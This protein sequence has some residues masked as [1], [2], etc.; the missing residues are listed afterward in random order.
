[1][2]KE[3]FKKACDKVQMSERQSEGIWERAE[4]KVEGNTRERKLPLRWSYVFSTAAAMI[5][6]CA[7]MVSTMWQSGYSVS[8]ENETEAVSLEEQEE[9]AEAETHEIFLY[10]TTPSLPDELMLM[11]VISIDENNREVTIYPVDLD[12]AIQ[13]PFREDGL[14][15]LYKWM[16]IK[17][18]AKDMTS[19][20]AELFGM[21]ESA[22]YVEMDML[23]LAEIIDACGGLDLEF[24]IDDIREGNVLYYAGR[25]NMPEYTA[26]LWRRVGYI[27]Q[28]DGPIAVGWMIIPKDRGEEELGLLREIE[29]IGQLIEKCQ[30][31]HD[32]ESFTSLLETMN[33]RLNYELS[34]VEL[35]EEVLFGDEQY[36]I[37][38][39]KIAL[40][41]ALH[42]EDLS[43]IDHETIED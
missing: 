10:V 39:E 25:V 22:G 11:S 16:Y 18:G 31:T 36:R 8:Q 29:A 14:S 27:E 24:E 37:S 20:L 17:Y 43:E 23:A 19:S 41:R 4:R 42:R 40:V 7:V 6:V 21:N 1:M 5:L 34:M 33:G 30:V 28:V 2:K 26:P 38:D 35:I 12:D 15:I 9:N 32:V 13:D 3:E